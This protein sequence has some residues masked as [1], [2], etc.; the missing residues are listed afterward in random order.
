MIEAS[1]IRYTIRGKEIL[2]GVSMTAY[3]GQV[4]AIIG[5]NGVGKSTLLKILSGEIKPTTG[6]VFLHKKSLDGIS[7]AERASCRCVLPQHSTLNFAF[8]AREVIEMGLVSS[9]Y[10]R[11]IFGCAEIIGDAASATGVSH[12]LDRMYLSLSGGERQRV[13]LA[14]VWAQYACC[15][16]DISPVILLDEPVSSLDLAFQHTVLRLA[17]EAASDGATVI[18]VLH[19]LHLTARYADQVIMMKNGVIYQS[20]ETDK[21]L[22]SDSI[23]ECY[24]ISPELIDGIHI[25]R[26]QHSVAL[27]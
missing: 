2:R 20:G 11:K 21:V 5:Q 15:R 10:T 19:D 9:R 14:R 8:T 26:P 24:D 7:L 27:Y 13:H 17:R 23:S 22:T 18:I 6:A 1:N 16:P 25:P 12:L 4:I 3:A